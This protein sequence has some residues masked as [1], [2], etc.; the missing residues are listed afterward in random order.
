MSDA[1]CGGCTPG[2]DR[3]TANEQQRNICAFINVRM[4]NPDEERLGFGKKLVAL[5]RDAI[6]SGRV[7]KCNYIKP[8]DRT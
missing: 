3:R 2:A 1:P 6:L 7:P 8:A 4:I 5:R